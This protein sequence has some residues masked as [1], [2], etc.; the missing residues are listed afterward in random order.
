MFARF[1]P[2]VVLVLTLS[3]APPAA[4]ADEHLDAATAFIESLSA[5]AITALTDPEIT[6]EERREK[7]RDLFREGFAV[8]GIAR[9]ALGRYWRGASEE[10]REE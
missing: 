2:A 3:I 1:I 8:D 5:R 4:R 7:F 9:F 10:D 6:G